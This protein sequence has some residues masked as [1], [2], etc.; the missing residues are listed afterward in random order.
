MCIID[1]REIRF[2]YYVSRDHNAMLVIRMFEYY[3]FVQCTRLYFC[4]N[5]FFSD[6]LCLPLDNVWPVDRVYVINGQKG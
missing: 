3:T 2:D 6:A 4:F 1:V 5:Y